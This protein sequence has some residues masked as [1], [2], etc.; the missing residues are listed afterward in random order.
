M[1]WNNYDGMLPAKP[2]KGKL[3]Y[4]PVSNAEEWKQLPD[5]Y[6]AMEWTSLPDYKDQNRP[7][8][9]KAVIFDVVYMEPYKIRAKVSV[10]PQEVQKILFCLYNKTQ[11]QLYTVCGVELEGGTQLGAKW[12]QDSV[13]GAFG[14]YAGGHFCGRQG[15]FRGFVPSNIERLDDGTFKYK[16]Y[17][18]GLTGNVVHYELSN[19][20]PEDRF[21]E[22][23]PQQELERVWVTVYK[24]TLGYQDENDNLAEI[25]VPQKWLQ[26]ALKAEGVE[27]YEQWESEYT[28]D[29]TDGIAEKALADYVIQ[30]CKGID[31]LT[32]GTEVE[33]ISNWWEVMDV[34]DGRVQLSNVNNGD[35]AHLSLKLFLK[36]AMPVLKDEP[37]KEP[38]EG[39]IA[40]AEAIGE[41]RGDII[42]SPEQG[43][44][45]D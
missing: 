33:Y 36:E 42:S 17:L 27:N 31:L 7:K 4:Y 10:H 34:K 40:S 37:G 3:G 23:K 21:A 22:K 32:L 12:Y 39:Q 30:G 20:F 29:M 15:G 19:P 16:H 26:D 35:P 2:L 28:A 18:R 45:R 13:T 5:L 6:K 44:E 11:C 1:N 8:A 43:I 24:D 14:I 38:L 9:V 41:N 25:L